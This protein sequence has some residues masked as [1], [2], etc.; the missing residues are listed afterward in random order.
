MNVLVFLTVPHYA[1]VLCCC[2]GNGKDKCEI[3]VNH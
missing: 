2:G 3:P 1:A